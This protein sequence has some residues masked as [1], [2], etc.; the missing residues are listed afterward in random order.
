MRGSELALR[1]TVNLLATHTLKMDMKAIAISNTG[2]YLIALSRFDEAR[3]HANEGLEL[4][5][6]LQM[7]AMIAIS[8]M[9]LALVAVLRPQVQGRN[10]FSAH[11]GTA[12]LL[13]WFEARRTELGI[14]RARSFGANMMRACLLFATGW[15]VMSWLVSWPQVRR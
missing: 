14:P 9:H 13:G 1:L 10:A 5:R 15:D 4:A 8:L 12:R 2:A 3:A 7:V 11:A 6:G